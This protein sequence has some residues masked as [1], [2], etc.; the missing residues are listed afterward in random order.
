VTTETRSGKH[1]S[2]L[3]FTAIVIVALGLVPAV[4]A[5][6]TIEI[7]GSVYKDKCTPCHADI[8]KTA[9]STVIFSHGN[10]IA[11]ACSS[12]HT[13]FPHRPQGT[14]MPTMKDCFV[15]HGLNHGP[16]GKMAT[17]KCVD[18]HK[19]APQKRRPVSHVADWAAKPHVA[20]SLAKLTTECAMCHTLAECDLCH[21]QEGVNWK[22]DVAF[23][24]DSQNGCQACH[25]NPDLTKTAAGGVLKSYFVTGI[26]ASA[27]RDTTCTQCHADFTHGDEKPETPIWSVNVGL[28]CQNCHDHEESA[29]QYQ[30]S[31]HAEKLAEG[32]LTSATCASCHGGHDIARLD[33]EAAKQ[34][35]HLSSEAMC[36]DCH[37]DYWDSY[38]DY[39]HGAAY[40][41]GALDAP[42]CWDCHG[43]HEMQPSSD[44]SS[45]VAPAN[46]ASTCS[47]GECH[48]QHTGASEDFVRATAQMIHGKQQVRAD[49][50]LVKLFRSIFGGRS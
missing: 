47:G 34:A 46:L 19:P 4:T 26:D 29:A 12:C 2:R 1:V 39:Y 3:V 42:A 5:A 27:H 48:D 8:N 24:Y 16:Q 22:P 45:S 7:G 20:P 30:R 23:I 41:R 18:C 43:A 44:A 14:L 21:L 35:L 50:P 17:A 49:N 10:H 28:A 13:Q 11:Y 9:D 32:D 6:L 15:C 40:K 31:V 36:A 37:R 33:T 38:S 25:G